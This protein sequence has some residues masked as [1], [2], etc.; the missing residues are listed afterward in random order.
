MEN[1][2][3]RIVV[4]SLV[5]QPVGYDGKSGALTRLAEILK[6]LSLLEKVKI[7]VVSS[8]AAFPDYLRENGV[9]FEGVSV[10][11]KL[12]FKSLTGL[13]FKSLYILA[14]SF[15][16][17]K[18][19]FLKRE[20]ERTIAYASSDLFWEVIPACWFKKRNGDILWVQVIH[21]IYP[22]WKTRPGRKT[23][24]F[25]GY[26]LQRFSFRLIKKHSDAIIVLNDNV[27]KKL[28]KL[29][30]SESRLKL[31]SNGIDF[32]YFDRMEKSESRYD[33]VFLGRLSPS[34]GIAD[35]AGIWKNVCREIPEAKI[36][37]IG[38]GDKEAKNFLLKKIEKDDLKKNIDF[39]GFLENEKAYSI[40]KSGKVFLFPSHEEGWG[41]AIAEAMACGLPV[42]SWDL[43]VYKSVFKNFTVQVEEGNIAKISDEIIRL[44]R[45]ENLRETIA[46]MGKEY[47]KKYSWDEVC[48]KEREIIRSCRI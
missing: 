48:A 3:Y 16:V 10:K 34:K 24:N 4:T 39:L 7:A 20:N 17:L 6:R 9:E 18:L 47:I 1:R 33:G 11:S 13:C 22:K 31:S 8:N 43:P 5:P 35:I 40:L 2:K 27:R 45:N 12:K 28:L 21:H 37:V 36:A 38:G 42:V 14:K 26:W 46:N 30:F 41:I 32:E 23:T 19:D 29:G 25:F 44:L 15:F